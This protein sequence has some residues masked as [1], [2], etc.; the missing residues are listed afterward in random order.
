MI[1]NSTSNNSGTIGVSESRRLAVLVTMARDGTLLDRRRV[2]LVDEGLPKFPH[3]NEGQA[4]P[5]DE[6]VP[7]G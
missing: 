1:G 3:H 5:L 4:L 7:E 6:A 2:E